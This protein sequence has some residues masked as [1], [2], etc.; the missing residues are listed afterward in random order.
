ML[1]DTKSPS[2]AQVDALLDE[3][4]KDSKLDVLEPSKELQKIGQLHA[5]YLAILSAH[6]RAFK[7]ANRTFAKLKR[8]KHEYYSGRLDQETLKKYNWNPFPYTLKTDLSI[9]MD[10]DPDALNA[11]R[12]IELHEEIVQVSESIIKELNSRTYQLK[13]II[14]WERFINGQ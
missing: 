14:T 13:D 6:R 3:W 2:Q 7:E 12:V 9:Y 11:K 4:K 10:S 5:K 8:I 1:L